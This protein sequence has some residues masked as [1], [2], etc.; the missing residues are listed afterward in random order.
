M[1][2][3]TRH[4]P[5]LLMLACLVGGCPLDMTLAAKRQDERRAR[6]EAANTQMLERVTRA[7]RRTIEPEVLPDVAASLR[8]WDE[9]V[10]WLRTG[11]RMTYLQARVGQSADL[12]V[13]SRPG[14][15]ADPPATLR[16]EHVASVE[17]RGAPYTTETRR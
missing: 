2:P 11:E 9:V 1:P 8:V 15:S 7:E 12:V 13:I 5:L 16:I 4:V 14:L 10:V 17:V 6:D 3:T